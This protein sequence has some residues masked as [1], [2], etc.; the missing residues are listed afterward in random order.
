[1]S[2]LHENVVKLNADHGGVCK[3]GNSVED[4]DN[5]KLVQSNIKDLYKKALKTGG[6]SAIS[7]VASREQRAKYVRGQQL[8]RH[9]ESDS[10]SSKPKRARIADCTDNTDSGNE[11]YDDDDDGDSGNGEGLDKEAYGGNYGDS[12][13]VVNTDEEDGEDEEDNSEEDDSG[14][15]DSSEEDSIDEDSESDYE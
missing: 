9:Q 10:T 11:S 2:G 6:L 15:E 12:S 13:E 8:K 14:E 7:S 4:H 5:F 1:M 3:F